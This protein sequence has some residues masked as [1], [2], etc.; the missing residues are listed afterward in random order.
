MKTLI[1]YVHGKGGSANECG[2]YAPLCSG[3]DV[4]GLDY[5]GDTPWD[6]GKEIKEA[7]LKLSPKYEKITLIANSIGAFFS[8]HA[9]IE[10]LIN[11]AYFISP[12]VDMES[13]ILGMMER[14]GVTDDELKRRGV[15][16]TQSGDELS[17]EYLFFVREHPL[18][19]SVPTKILYGERDLLTPYGAVLRF[20][21]E[22][23]ASLTVM[24]GGEH[25]FHTEEQMCFLDAWIKSN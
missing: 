20:A 4:R 9:G 2:H 24:P 11:D 23:G 14:E 18:K 6:A 16:H 25:W 22:R 21:D 8:M 19:W 5:S 3:C 12:I 10:D 17:W 1:L 13:L 15:I 7:I